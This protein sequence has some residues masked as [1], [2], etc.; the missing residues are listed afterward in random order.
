MYI[1]M[2]C[3]HSLVGRGGNGVA[4]FTLQNIIMKELMARLFTSRV[5]YVEEWSWATLFISWHPIII[6]NQPT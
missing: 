3:H 4:G 5:L 2:D 6:G 1:E